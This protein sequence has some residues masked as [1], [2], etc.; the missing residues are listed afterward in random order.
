LE[1]NLTLRGW[2]KLKR[3][4]RDTPRPEREFFVVSREATFLRNEDAQRLVGKM[5]P[6]QRDQLE[7][8][9]VEQRATGMDSRGFWKRLMGIIRG[10]RRG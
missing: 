6:K 2:R 10:R 9:V 5:S 7:E 1:F 3:R 8:L 4:W